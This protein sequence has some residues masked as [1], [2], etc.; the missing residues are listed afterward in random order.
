MPVFDLAEIFPPKQWLRINHR[1]DRLFIGIGTSNFGYSS[2]L[3]PENKENSTRF[4]GFNS[5]KVDF[6]GPV[7]I[8]FKFG[9]K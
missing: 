2:Q 6:F 7:S 4:P 9:K 3:K 5:R 1:N 8:L